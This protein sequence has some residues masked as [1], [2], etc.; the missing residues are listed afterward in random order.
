MT[1][2]ELRKALEGLSGDLPITV[3]VG[4]KFYD[5]DEH[6]LG[7]VHTEDDDGNYS[8]DVVTVYLVAGQEH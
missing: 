7:D 3:K 2:D 4:G 1:V 5:L 6:E 8:D